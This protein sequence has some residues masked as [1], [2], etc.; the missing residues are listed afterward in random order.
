MSDPRYEELLAAARRA[1]TTLVYHESDLGAIKRLAEA[2][3]AFDPKRHVFGGVVFEEVGCRGAR[4]GEWYVSNSADRF[5]SMASYD[6]TG[7]MT[8]LRPVAL[9]GGDE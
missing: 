4:G 3:R 7:P 6:M 9:E 5:P 2:V 8:I 1:S